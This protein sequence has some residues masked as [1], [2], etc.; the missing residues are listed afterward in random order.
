MIEA[1]KAQGGP[2]RLSYGMVGGG[3]GAFIGEVHRKAIATDGKARL[4]AGSFSRDNKKTLAAGESLGVARERLYETYEEMA[5]KE[6]AR[7]DGI[8]FVVIVT[9]NH[10]HFPI[11]KTFLES[12]INVV[13]DKP[14]VHSS[15]QAEELKRLAARK[16]RLFCVTY[17][18]TGYPMMKQARRMVANG[19]IGDIRFVSAEYLQDWL[20]TPLENSG[21]KQ[22]E[23]RTDPERSGIAGCLGDIGTHVENSVAY[24]TGLS[25]ASVSAR[26]DTIVSGRRL[27]DNASIMVRYSNGAQGLYWTSQVAVGHDND[28][29]VRVF[30][31]KGAVE[32]VQENPNYLK[33]SHLDRPGEVLSRGR[34]K[35]YP[36]AAMF[37]RIPGGHPEGYPEAFSNLYR[38]FCD[39]LVK[40][41]A[42]AKL[43]AADL[44]FPGLDA[45]AAGVK[46]VER[47]VESSRKG[48][49]WTNLE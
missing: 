18:Y 24:I 7:K 36:E 25:I 19:D 37:S 38:S 29:R 15:D 3:E 22:A 11:A 20:A 49:A 21:S 47:C 27:D 2:A 33:V 42:G 26:L 9:P 32:W 30:G 35:L 1:S 8:D 10:L 48:A 14:L 13:C 17:T 34:D 39:A 6:A 40:K 4:V 44:D 31:S 46:F 28:L 43:T 23:W 5:K 41:S 16:D 45:G 12:G